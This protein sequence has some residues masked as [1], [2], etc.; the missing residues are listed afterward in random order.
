[1]SIIISIMH[2]K[3]TSPGKSINNDVRNDA[4]KF[5]LNHTH[6]HTHTEKRQPTWNARMSSE[7]NEQEKKKKLCEIT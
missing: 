6:T 4:S 7:Q 3:I 1:M 5:L 2:G